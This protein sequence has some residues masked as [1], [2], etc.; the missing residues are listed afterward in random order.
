MDE[1]VEITDVPEDKVVGIYGFRTRKLFRDNGLKADIYFNAVEGCCLAAMHGRNS[2][3][4]CDWELT[5]EI[6]FRVQDL[7]RFGRAPE[8]VS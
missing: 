2:V 7:A 6:R 1:G 3:L 8:V 5:E 4:Y